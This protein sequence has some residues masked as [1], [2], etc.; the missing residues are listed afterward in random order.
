MKLSLDLELLDYLALKISSNVRSLEGA[1]IRIAT[2]SSLTKQKIT[3]E[4]LQE[5]LRDLIKKE[6]TQVID[7]D[8]IQRTVADHFSI[9]LRSD[10]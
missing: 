7:I 10:W 3:Q 4:R 1:L 5:L 9:S 6:E 2:F 8:L